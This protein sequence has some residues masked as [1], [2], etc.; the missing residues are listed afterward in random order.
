MSNNLGFVT[1]NGKSCET[2]SVFDHGLLYGDGIYETIRVFN[3]R[4]FLFDDHLKR[5]FLS[6]TTISLKI[7]YSETELIK[8]IKSAFKKSRLNDAFIRII[9]TRGIGKQ[10]LVCESQPNVIIMVNSRE[11]NPL[12]K[13]SITISKIRRIDKNAID[14]KV[15]SLNYLNNILAK[16]DALTRN[17]DDAL[18]LNNAGLLTEATTS[19]LFIVKNGK[20]FTPSSDSGILE[21]ITRKAILEN[22][23]V[24]EKNLSIKELLSADEVF[25]S[26]TVNFITC[27]KKIDDQNFSKFDHAKKVLDNLMQITEIGTELK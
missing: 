17:F 11:F 6:A 19:N 15:K 22:F 12:E 10:G 2:I 8:M 3:K 27:V 16:K 24:T 9:V 5:L 26:G 14:S 21:G 1:I 25:L 23:N 4:A 7:P 18:L 13:I 20:I